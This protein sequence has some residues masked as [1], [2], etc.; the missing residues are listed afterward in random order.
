VTRWRSST[1]IQALD[2]IYD[3]QQEIRRLLEEILTEL[4]R[5]STA[6]EA[7]KR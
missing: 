2:A 6:L 5:I 4:R 3:G 1:E 7:Q